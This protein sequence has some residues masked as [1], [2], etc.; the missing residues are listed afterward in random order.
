LVYIFE[1]FRFS[2]PIVI[3]WPPNFSRAVR[4]LI[5]YWLFPQA[6]LAE[7]EEYIAAIAQLSE[8]EEQLKIE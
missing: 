6:E 2:F 1:N 4:Y 3:K 7:S 5:N 8:A